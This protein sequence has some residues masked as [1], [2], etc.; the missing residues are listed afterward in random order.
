M[1]VLLVD[2]QYAQLESKQQLL[3]FRNYWF[4]NRFDELQYPLQTIMSKDPL[5]VLH[6]A[7]DHLQTDASDLILKYVCTLVW[8]V[9][10]FMK[11]SKLSFANLTTI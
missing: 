1:R 9:M 4:K 2:N 8:F 3:R 6:H 7:D 5:V 11:T 10:S